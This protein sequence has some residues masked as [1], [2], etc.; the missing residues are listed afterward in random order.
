MTFEGLSLKQIKEIFFGRWESEFKAHL[1]K[2]Q[3]TMLKKLQW[4]NKT[5][6]IMWRPL[7]FSLLRKYVEH[8]ITWIWRAQYCAVLLDIWWN[9]IIKFSK[10]TANS[11]ATK[12]NTKPCKT[13]EMELFSQV[14][15]SFKGKLR[16]SP[17][18]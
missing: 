6:V 18:I 12:A 16:I 9:M 14:V 10:Q 17:K 4:N 13:S 3:L 2:W 5:I 8:K 15:T 1:C 11:F 7:Q